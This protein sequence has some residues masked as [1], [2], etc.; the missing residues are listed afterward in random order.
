M[1]TF[2]EIDEAILA[3]VN[4]DGEILDAEA[5]TAL[6]MERGR[7]IESMALWVLDL[8]D[9]QDAIKREIDRL[10]A[11]KKAA[12]TKEKRLKE[13]LQAILGGDKFKSDR[14]TV[15]YRTT[16]AV[17]I[18]DETALRDWA[19][20]DPK[21]EGVLKFREPEISKTALKELLASGTEIPG[22]AMQTKTS[23]IIK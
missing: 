1:G 7:K 21:G 15:S 2:R 16:Q 17:E 11:R 4:E 23:T 22:A 19:E 13:F 12:E 3:L 14:V 18:T 6:Q 8:Q 20:I 9:E 10:T 5:F